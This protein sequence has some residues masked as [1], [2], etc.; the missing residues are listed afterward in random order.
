MDYLDFK[1]RK[2]VNKYIGVPQWCQV[3]FWRKLR[4]NFMH[5]PRSKLY[6]ITNEITFFQRSVLPMLY[7]SILVAILLAENFSLLSVF[8]F[9][10]ANRVSVLLMFFTFLS[11]KP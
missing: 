7:K 10:G 3:S 11:N 4:Y 6:L 9:T 8:L 1:Q 5:Q 2:P